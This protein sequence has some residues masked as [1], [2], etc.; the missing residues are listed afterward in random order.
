MTNIP[1]IEK[2]KISDNLW[3]TFRG[4]KFVFGNSDN[5]EFHHTISLGNRSGYFDLH[6]TNQKTNEH[7]TIIRWEHKNA[8]DVYPHIF[9]K[10]LKSI[11]KLTEF[12]YDKYAECITLLNDK[13]YDLYTDF[14]P[15]IK[16][17]K[18]TLNIEHKNFKTIV[19]QLSDEVG[20]EKI[21]VKELIKK[22]EFISIV[23]SENEHFFIL[24][25][26]YLDKIYKI[27]SIDLNFDNTLR[28]VFGNEVYDEILN[29]IKNALNS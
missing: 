12:D 1:Q 4:N 3:I 29:R 26:Q 24:K 10:A 17:N 20:F 13:N 16:K 19:E 27:E 7:T 25:N 18:I 22:D 14:L 21:K 8:F 11:F 15:L 28:N 5:K 9:S 23:E 2:I 6:I